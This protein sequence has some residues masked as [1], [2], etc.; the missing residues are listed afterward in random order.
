M[1]LCNYYP[2]RG[3][4][5]VLFWLPFLSLTLWSQ[6]RFAHLT[7]PHIFEKSGREKEAESN[8]L[9][10]DWCVSKINALNDSGEKFDFVVVTG[11][12]GLENL[13]TPP[14]NPKQ[15]CDASK[16]NRKWKEGLEK[17]AMILEES[18][19]RKWFFIPGNNDLY[20]ER[21]CNI[22][23]YRVFIQELADNPRLQGKIEAQDLV[24]NPYAIN[25]HFFLGF[26]NAFF[27]N[28]YDFKR[29]ERSGSHERLA[30]EK[31][32]EQM[33]RNDSDKVYIFYHIPEVDDPWLILAREGRD[34]AALNQV[35]KRLDSLSPETRR[36]QNITEEDLQKYQYSSW[37]VYPSTRERWS[38]VSESERVKGLFVGHFHTWQKNDYLG[39][40]WLPKG[41]YSQKI[42]RK[43]YLAPPIALKNQADAP[44]HAR[45]FAEVL[46]DERG[47]VSR[48]VFWYESGQASNDVPKEDSCL[49]RVLILVSSFIA[50]VVLIC[51]LSWFIDRKKEKS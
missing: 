45:G 29:L 11:D 40:D 49:K 31:V 47:G 41:G 16:G 3:V 18:A 25:G 38:S 36:T 14:E 46:L 24:Q 2:R 15:P 27:K 48:N 35:K 26:D 32:A 44:H 37:T 42:L 43:L 1:H 50:I 20:D 17:L 6:V 12:L 21:P 23:H 19:I 9:T 28:E 33:D 7:D 13:L 22:H 5:L 4:R 30:I 10:F 34:Q 39:F 8:E 51:G